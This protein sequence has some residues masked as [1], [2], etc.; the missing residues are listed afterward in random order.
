MQILSETVSDG[1]WQRTFVVGDITRCHLVT[2]Q[3]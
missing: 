1:V 2:L 3:L